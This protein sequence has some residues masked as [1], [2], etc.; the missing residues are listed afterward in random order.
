MR[1]HITLANLVALRGKAWVRGKAWRLR[2]VRENR[3]VEF[4]KQRW[5]LAT[6]LILGIM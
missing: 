4:S 5:G 1:L 6:N 2:R 3:I